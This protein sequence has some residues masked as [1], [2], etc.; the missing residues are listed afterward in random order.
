MEPYIFMYY[1]IHALNVQ[2]NIDGKTWYEDTFYLTKATHFTD[3]LTLINLLC[4]NRLLRQLELSLCS[5]IARCS[6]VYS[7]AFLS[8]LPK[9]IMILMLIQSQNSVVH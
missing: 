7:T 2:Q 4:S 5:V 9:Y 1:P 6:L 3:D 8:I